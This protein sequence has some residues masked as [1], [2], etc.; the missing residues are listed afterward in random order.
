MNA[1][2]QSFA[3]DL[4]SPALL[5]WTTLRPDHAEVWG[6]G[7]E[8]AARALLKGIPRGVPVVGGAELHVP[9]VLDMLT[10]NEN[11][12]HTPAVLTSGRVFSHKEE[13]LALAESA[14]D[15]T[16]AMFSLSPLAVEQA[17]AAM[18]DLPPDVADFRVLRDGTDELGI[19]F[20]AND[21]K[22]TKRLFAETNWT[23]EETTLLYHHRPDRTA[24]LKDFLP[25]I[26][27]QPWKEIIFTRT[28]RP[29][30]SSQFLF[31]SAVTW[32]DD[33][34]SPEAFESWR[35]DRGRVFACGNAAGWPVEFL[36]KNR[37]LFEVTA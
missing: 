23:P 17:R 16:S 21:L 32:N 2:L 6:H 4:V 27:A 26:N 13:N 5:V 1:E 35:K 9:F 30:F 34:T 31:G 37:L 14:I 19:A 36:L 24:R 33:L 20:S 12:L 25:W 29:W 15:L 11:A 28:S 18:S 8:G 22:S 7:I 3:P 10:A